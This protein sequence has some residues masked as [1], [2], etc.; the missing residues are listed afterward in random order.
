MDSLS[1]CRG[2]R[3]EQSYD[4]RILL[5]Q[6]SGQ[7]DTSR[8]QVPNQTSHITCSV[9]VVGS[10]SQKKTGRIGIP[11]HS[12]EACSEVETHRHNSLT[13]VFRTLTRVFRTLGIPSPEAVEPEGHQ[14]RKPPANKQQKKQPEEEEEGEALEALLPQHQPKA[15]EEKEEEQVAE[16]EVVTSSQGLKMACLLPVLAMLLLLFLS[17][18]AGEV[19]MVVAMEVDG[20]A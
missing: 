13:R 18:E 16:V 1:G 6:W 2:S 14:A 20:V 9:E 19:A 8:C 4:I 15:Q 12:S 3:K 11:M 10:P 17:W 7:A 5:A